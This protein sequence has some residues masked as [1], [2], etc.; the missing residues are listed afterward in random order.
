[1]ITILNAYINHKL[2]PMGWPS[3]LTLHRIQNNH[4]LQKKVI[5][6]INILKEAKNSKFLF[7]LSRN[8]ISD[9]QGLE[10]SIQALRK[11]WYIYLYLYTCLY[12]HICLYRH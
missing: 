12:M 4:I 6:W 3:I 10:G 5:K 7:L 8:E 2:S 1:M 11:S 9:I